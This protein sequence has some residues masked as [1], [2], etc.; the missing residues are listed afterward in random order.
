ML[1]ARCPQCGAPTPVSAA[2]PDHL[3]CAYC[4]YVGPP[5]PDVEASLRAAAAVLGRM[6]AQR[7]Q[8]S[9]FQHRTLGRMGCSMTL[10]FVLLGALALPF[11]VSA[12]ACTA[13]RDQLDT[14]VL[15][16]VGFGPL[17][18]LLASGAFGWWWM[19]RSRG[20]L[21]LA[22]A[23]QPPAVR[24]RPACCRVCGGDLA[25]A[26]GA[27][28]ER[29]GFC[30][31]DNV[32]SQGAMQR[33]WSEQQVVLGGYEQ[34]VRARAQAAGSSSL[35]ATLLVFLVGTT[36][37]V[38]V[39]FVGFAVAMGLEMH[40][41]PAD[42]SQQYV[43]VDTPRGKCLALIQHYPGGVEAYDFED[44]APVG[45]A[46]R[47]RF[48]PGSFKPIG[49]KQLTGLT[50]LDKDGLA[51]K[52]KRVYRTSLREDDNQIQLV[53]REG[54]YPPS[55]SVVGSCLAGDK[56]PLR[57]LTYQDRGVP[58]LVARPGGVLV[59]GF[60]DALYTVQGATDQ[61]RI[62]RTTG[63]DHVRAMLADTSAVYLELDRQLLRV[64]P[65]GK[66]VALASMPSYLGKGI[67][68][69]GDTL[70]FAADGGVSR[71]P[72][73]GGKVERA[74]DDIA[75]RAL[76]AGG[77]A[78]ALIDPHSDVA[79]LAAGEDK[80]RTVGH[81]AMAARGV[82]IADDRVWWVTADSTLVSSPV[83]GGA[84]KQ[85]GKLDG[86]DGVFKLRNG[87]VW[88]TRRWRS[89]ESALMSRPLPGGPLAN[90]SPGAKNV[91]AFGFDGADLYWLDAR[92]HWLMRRKL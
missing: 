85:Y 76:G 34:A 65:D 46:P 31:A 74:L 6:Q 40:E 41:K 17:I 9:Q 1:A 3:D 59:I 57:V 90:H 87:E 54:D 28:V 67:A 56:P 16:L 14:W 22:C 43:A 26:P 44:A 82:A 60:S 86:I 36:A 92:R 29:C 89:V 39:M 8:L 15:L 48:S 21:E 71:V 27:V 73:T 75:A 69:D 66:A 83:A 18:M 5:P 91:D 47:A 80:A 25:P 62:W 13:M 2:R 81:D 33:R 37:P 38:L 51:R 20:A 84:L 68:L 12:A 4:S 32:V 23:A 50:V 58:Q 49:V 53:S 61:R 79:V 63:V 88:W 77:G 52:V 30:G 72:R 45:V 24:G 70:Y 19:R 78:L 42:V 11:A 35:N 64:T 55:K 7:R 10:F